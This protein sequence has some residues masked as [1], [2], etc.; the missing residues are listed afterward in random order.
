MIPVNN[1]DAQ[2]GNLHREGHPARAKRAVEF[3]S[4]SVTDTWRP[5]G[6]KLDC[7]ENPVGA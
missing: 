3:S 1:S 5:Q 6:I 2:I 7:E 4:P